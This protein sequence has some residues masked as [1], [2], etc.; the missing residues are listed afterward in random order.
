MQDKNMLILVSGSTG[1][2]KTTIIRQAIQLLGEQ[3]LST[4]PTC[5]T[6]PP[7]LGETNGKDYV[8]FDKQEFNKAIKDH[9]IIEA[10][11]VYNNYY[12]TYLPAILQKMQTSK[13]LIKDFDVQ[14]YQNVQKR[15]ALHLQKRDLSVLPM[16]TI[17]IDAPDQILLDRIISRNDNTNVKERESELVVERGYKTHNH[18]DYRIDNSTSDPSLAL[19]ELCTILQNEYHSIYKEPLFDEK[20]LDNISSPVMQDKS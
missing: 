4:F 6:R 16:V 8:F 14:G 5:T 12:G 15:I 10:K 2:G 19:R 3:N 13:V 20:I 7:R 18:Y 9:D 17:L 1:A 11:K